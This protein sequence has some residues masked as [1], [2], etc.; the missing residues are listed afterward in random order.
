MYPGKRGNTGLTRNN[1]EMTVE[2]SETERLCA[3]AKPRL[4]HAVYAPSLCVRN[5]KVGTEKRV[6]VSWFKMSH[7]SQ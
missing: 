6:S 2:I 7:C 3:F 4:G 5:L 1:G